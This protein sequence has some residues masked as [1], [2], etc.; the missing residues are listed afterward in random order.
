M[1]FD[2]VIAGVGGQGV[3]TIAAVL[4]RAAHE[5]GLYV[6]QS[7]VHGMAQRGGAVSAF[8]R[9]SDQPINSDLIA[10]GHASLLLSIEP[11]EALRYT[12]LLKPDGWI[13][14]DITPMLNVSNYPPMDEVYRVLFSAPRLVALDAT[15]LAQKAGTIKAQNV[16]ALGAA[17]MHLPLPME[18]I[19]TQIR[20]LFERK[21][22]RIVNANLHAFRKGDAA[23][24]FTSALL[25]AGIAG[26]TVARITS[27]IHFPPHPVAG[28]LVEAWCQRLKADADQTL[29]L[30]RAHE[31][32]MRLDTLAE[33]ATH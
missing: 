26:Q 2:L 15:R 31:E 25:E 19:E 13:V 30:L 28:E 12:Q 33:L 4:D 3:L 14:S 5:A 9:M 1:N 6:K 27:H 24:R 23:A 22:E 10:Q 18:L 21:G 7:E 16:V 32:L 11:L 29:Q 17:A 8:V 20:A